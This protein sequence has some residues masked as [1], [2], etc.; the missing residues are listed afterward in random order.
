MRIFSDDFGMEIP[1]GPATDVSA[2]APPVPCGTGPPTVM[3]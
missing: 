3:I 1:P 2:Y